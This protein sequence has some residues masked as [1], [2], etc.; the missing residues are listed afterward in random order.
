MYHHHHH[1]HVPCLAT[2]PQLPPKRVL[3]KQRYNACAFNYKYPHVSLRLYNS[4]LRP[5]TCGPVTSVLASIS[6]S[7]T[8]FRRQLLRK[9]W[10][11]QLAFLLF[12]I[13][14]SMQYFFI[15]HTI[16]PTDLQHPSPAPHF[17]TSQVFLIYFPKCPSFSTPQSYANMQCVNRKSS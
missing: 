16:G 4:C 7:I 6:P 10:P 13:C 15:S 8:C 3:H 14:D 11:T 9:M 5:L 17:K 1:H 12:I 2:G